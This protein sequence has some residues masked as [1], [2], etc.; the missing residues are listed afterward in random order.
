MK[1]CR[2]KAEAGDGGASWWL[3]TC[4]Q[5]GLRGLAKDNAQARAWYER[6]AAARDPRG[7]ARFGEC[8]LCGKGGPKNHAHGLVMV[9]HAA[10]LGSDVGAYHLGQVF[11]KGCCGL[12]KDP[13]QARFWLEKAVGECEYNNLND[14]S[15]AKAAEWLRELEDE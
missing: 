11:F 6:S 5:F 8:L 4:Y 2:A 12:P 10:G 9:T 1:E 15:L 14:G 13:A 3:G 7:M